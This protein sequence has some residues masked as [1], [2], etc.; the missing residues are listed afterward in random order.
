MIANDDS[1]D[2]YEDE[3]LEGQGSKRFRKVTVNEL[4]DDIRS[5]RSLGEYHWEK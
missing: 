3:D 1:W 5:V 2:L 4:I